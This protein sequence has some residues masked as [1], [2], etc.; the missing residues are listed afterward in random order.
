MLFKEIWPCLLAFCTEQCNN[1]HPH[2]NLPVNDDFSW[3][4]TQVPE[5]TLAF[6]YRACKKHWNMFIC[7][8]WQRKS[9]HTHI[10][11]T[12]NSQGSACVW[13]HIVDFRNTCV[14][15][16]VRIDGCSGDDEITARLT[17]LWHWVFEEL[18]K[19]DLG[20]CTCTRQCYGI[21]VCRIGARSCQCWCRWFIWGGEQRDR[22]Y[23]YLM[24]FRTF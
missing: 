22:S 4:G 16:I 3:R 8:K 24:P 18:I 9:W 12:C 10:V 11:L 15:S 1:D 7:L 5:A 17:A 23:Q 13:S 2:N 6:K 20:R 14:G 19:V 21:A